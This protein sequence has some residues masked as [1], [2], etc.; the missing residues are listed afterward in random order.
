MGLNL[1]H[2][3]TVVLSSICKSGTLK[4][5]LFFTSQQYH[6]FRASAEHFGMEANYMKK[7]EFQ[8]KDNSKN[9]SCT[10][11]LTIIEEWING[12]LSSSC[13]MS[14]ESRVRTIPTAVV[15]INI[16]NMAFIHTQNM[17]TGTNANVNA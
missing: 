10:L 15:G 4:L 3:S 11:T 13:K 14:D 1:A 9:I 17:R 16:T 6:N 12:D 5:Q 8:Y 7:Q 2:T